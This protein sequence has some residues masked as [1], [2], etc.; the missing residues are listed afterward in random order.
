MHLISEEQEVT[1]S[2]VRVG[3]N[4]LTNNVVTTVWLWSYAWNSQQ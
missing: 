3:I 1:I 2:N 4:N